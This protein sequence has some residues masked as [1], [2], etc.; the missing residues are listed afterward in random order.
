MVALQTLGA[1]V[2]L[3]ALQ[4]LDARVALGARVA[5]IALVAFRAGGARGARIALDPWLA[6]GPCGTRGP[7][8]TARADHARRSSRSLVPAR[9]PAAAAT[10]LTAFVPAA[11]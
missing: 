7:G 5:L 8:R 3:I 11:R 1:G 4:A 9:S 2:A 6:V 10:S